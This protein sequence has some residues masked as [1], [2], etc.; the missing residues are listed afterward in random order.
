MSYA[1]TDGWS[2]TTFE[3]QT[4]SCCGQN[5]LCHNQGRLDVNSYAKQI[6]V[7]IRKTMEKTIPKIRECP[8]VKNNPWTE[9]LTV[10]STKAKEKVSTKRACD[11][12][13]DNIHGNTLGIKNRDF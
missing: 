6:K 7:A 1:T 12:G 4:V 11:S 3:R 9:E 5:V 10:L 2:C 8:S 13:Q